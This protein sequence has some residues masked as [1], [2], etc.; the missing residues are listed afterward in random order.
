MADITE[1]GM[2]GIGVVLDGCLASSDASILFFSQSLLLVP[3]EE[4]CRNG[5]QKLGTID[6]EEQRDDKEKKKKIEDH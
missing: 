5:K 1:V 2:G 3:V 6:K 4:T